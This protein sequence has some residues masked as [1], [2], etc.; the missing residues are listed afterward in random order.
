MQRAD[1][2]TGTGLHVPS[3]PATA[4]D[5]HAAVQAALQQN[6]WAQM[7]DTHSPLSTQACPFGLRPH[8]PLALQT[9][10]VTQSAA[11]VAAVQL[12]LHVEPPHLNVPHD[13]AAGVTQA[14]APSQVEAAVDVF[15]AALQDIPLH[16]VPL[17]YF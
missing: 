3:A 5:W 15:V 1:A 16:T 12:V 11:V 2:P 9:L 8:R 7:P 14:P 10:G 13:I 6:P 4:H 17:E